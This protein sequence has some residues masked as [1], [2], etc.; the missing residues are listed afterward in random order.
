MCE[1]CPAAAPDL[2]LDSVEAAAAARRRARL[3]EIDGQWHCM[4][5][6]TCLS[7][8]ELKSAAGKL[9][10]QMRSAKPTAYEIHTSMIHLITRERVVGKALHKLLDRKHSVA[11]NRSRGLAGAEALTAW[12][13]EA[14]AKGDVAAPCWAVMTH[15]DCTDELRNRVFGDV[16]MLSHQ[17][18]AAARTDQRAADR[19]E[20]EKEELEAKAAKRQE[21]LLAEITRRN[22]EIRELRRLLELEAAESRRLGHAARA[23]GDLDRL[24][25]TLDET[26]KALELESLSLI[27]I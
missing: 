4:I 24:S 14:L 18:S 15:P 19:L 25:R 10:V 12:W 9:G 17:L 27:H 26:R 13:E 21:R 23:A 22:D 3:W 20:K 1:L 16:H 6:G 8:G 11:L 2:D 7:F 5:V